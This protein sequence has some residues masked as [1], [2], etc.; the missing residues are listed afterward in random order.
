MMFLGWP[1]ILHYKA[2]SNGHTCSLDRTEVIMV[3]VGTLTISDNIE[4][5]I[6]PDDVA[7]MT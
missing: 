4:P 1:I 7:S 3:R 5:G 6:E 2:S